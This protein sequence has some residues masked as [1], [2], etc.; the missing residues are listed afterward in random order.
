MHVGNVC[1]IEQLYDT[2]GRLLEVAQAPA[3]Q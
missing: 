3:G 2:Q 1:R